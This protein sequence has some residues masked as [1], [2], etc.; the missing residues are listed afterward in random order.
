MV[1]TIR[2]LIADDHSLV[3]RGTRE[4]LHQH[5]DIEV[6]GEAAD[7]EET[8]LLIEQTQPEI[9]LIDLAMPG[10]SG[11]DATRHITERWPAIR[12]IVLTVHGD[13]EHV[14]EAIRAG[15][16]GFLLKN[17]SDRELIN[18]VFA[19]GEGGAIIDTSLVK[20]LVAG[21][22][23]PSVSEAKTDLLTQRELDVLRLAARGL[24]NS[25]VSGRLG[26]SSRTVE[27]H[28]RNIFTK[29]DV[30]TRTAAAIAGLSSG[31]LRLE[32]LQ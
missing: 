27:V 2:V 12:V 9:V 17:V 26:L 18:A 20:S 19:V 29:L 22:R 21:V 13:D 8:L 31:L 16:S 24:T 4:I 28:L 3:R 6:V 23:N 7:G 32:E 15:A 25:E 1:D 11:M 14:F 30:N 5:P 10:M